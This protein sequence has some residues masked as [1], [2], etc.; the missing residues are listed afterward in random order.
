MKRILFWIILI[1]LLFYVGVQGDIYI[2]GKQEIKVDG[3]VGEEVNQVTLEI[4]GISS[5]V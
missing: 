1:I 2:K 5:A 3:K 4:S